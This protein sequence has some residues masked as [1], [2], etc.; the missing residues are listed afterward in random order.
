[1]SPSLHLLVW[2]LLNHLI[3]VPKEYL[4]A[5]FDPIQVIKKKISDYPLC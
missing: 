1:M 2:D 5:S 3:S 4:S